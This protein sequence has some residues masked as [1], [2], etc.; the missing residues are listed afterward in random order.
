MGKKLIY[1]LL[2][3]FLGGFIVLQSC[4]ESPV[5]TNNYGGDPEIMG[6]D[7][8]TNQ[9]HYFYG[10]TLPGTD[11]RPVRCDSLDGTLELYSGVDH[12]YAG[13]V[14]Y[15]E[16]SGNTLTLKIY[17]QNAPPPA[18]PDPYP[19]FVTG[20]HFWAS[21]TGPPPL[22]LAFG[23]TWQNMTITDTVY[24]SNEFPIEFNVTLPGTPETD[25]YYMAT[26]LSL[27]HPGGLEGFSAYLPDGTV[28]YNVIRDGAQ[29]YYYKI[30]FLEGTEGYLNSPGP[31]ESWCV[32]SDLPIHP[33]VTLTGTVY[34]SYEELPSYLQTSIEHWGNL[35]LVNWILNNFKVGDPIKQ[36]TYADPITTAEWPFTLSK[37][38]S[39]TNFG[40]LKWQDIQCAIWALLETE[41]LA[42]SWNIA[43]GY[44]AGNVWSLIYKALTMVPTNWVP[45]C[46]DKVM[47]IMV[48]DGVPG[49]QIITIQPTIISLQMPCT[50]VCGTAMAD[51]RTGK[52]IATQN[53]GQ[54]QTY[55][56]WRKSPTPCP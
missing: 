14:E 19:W 2:A 56:M 23:S 53:P 16:L 30:T 8:L 51:S 10:T 25:L 31:Y 39:T 48:P 43:P 17:L 5:I 3:V 32:D 33:P 27:C 45:G 36:F 22:P 50:T 41:P 20:V 24:E 35:D 52:R 40:T 1:L 44:T 38:D 55:Y 7:N 21:L 18:A 26:H 4:N 42:D 37:F 28:K 49:I 6:A 13:Y 29:Q 54:W 46:N 12:R 9:L 15:S 47:A 11:L 34:S